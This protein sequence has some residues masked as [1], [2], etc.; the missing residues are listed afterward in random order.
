MPQDLWE[1]KHIAFIFEKRV[2]K[3]I[4]KMCHDYVCSHGRCFFVFV[5]TGKVHDSVCSH[6]RCFFIF[7]V[8]C[9]HGPACYLQPCILIDM[10]WH[11]VRKVALRICVKH[12]KLCWLKINR[13]QYTGQKKYIYFWGR[14]RNG[15]FSYQK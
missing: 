12:E 11:M 5:V 3:S 6:G 7:V 14:L 4:F 15:I 10:R 13:Y 2:L 9:R 1:L 8:S